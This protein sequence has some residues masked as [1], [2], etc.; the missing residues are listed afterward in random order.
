M[1]STMDQHV[2]IYV[3]DSKTAKDMVSKLKTIYKRD[4]NQQKVHLLQEY[5]NYKYNKSM[6]M[7]ENIS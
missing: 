2:N 5:Y 7:M 1:L 6:N 3:L 4:S